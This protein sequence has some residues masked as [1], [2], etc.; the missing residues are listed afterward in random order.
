MNNKNNNKLKSKFKLKEKLKITDEV[1]NI[2]LLR[3][4][5]SYNILWVIYLYF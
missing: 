2:A 4:K 3:E 1:K 5:V